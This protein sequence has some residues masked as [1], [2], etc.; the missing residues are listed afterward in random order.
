MRENFVY[1]YGDNLYVNLTNKCCNSCDFCIRKNGDGIGDSGCLWLDREPAAKECI[2]LI[3]KFLHEEKGFNEVVFCGYGEPLMRFDTVME[4]CRYIKKN[5]NA[6]IRI[7][8]NGHANHCAGRDVT[9]EMKGLVDTISIS[10]NASTAAEYQ[11]I[12]KCDFGEDGFWEMLD[13]AK[14]AKEYVP[15][16]VLSVVDVIG[17]DEIE[18]CRKI[19]QDIG[20]EYRV[21][22]YSE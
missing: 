19:V 15:H 7:N 10:L 3:E 1:R 5:S 11:K 22:E 6:S 17:K 21:R 18:A 2:D 12:C 14:K 20:V 16:V 13:F 8:T 4:V 9:P